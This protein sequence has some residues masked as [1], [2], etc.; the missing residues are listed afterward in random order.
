MKALATESFTQVTII[1]TE[2][3]DLIRKH[4]RA[5]LLIF[6]VELYVHSLVFQHLTEIKSI[7]ELIPFVGKLIQ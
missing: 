5:A 7:I 3:L 2:V 1:V 6:I 4:K